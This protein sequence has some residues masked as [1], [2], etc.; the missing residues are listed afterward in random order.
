M[1]QLLLHGCYDS[2]TLHTL[3][4]LGVKRFGFD[5][6]ATS[7]NLVP[8][9]QL[10]TLLSELESAEVVLTFQN[11]KQETVMSFLDLL[12]EYAGNLIVEFRDTQSAAYYY[13]LGHSFYWMFNE[14]ADWQSILRLPSLKGILLPLSMRNRYQHLSEMWKLIEAQGLEV[15]LHCEK[16]ESALELSQFDDTVISLDLNQ[17]VE[18]SYRQVDQSKL[19]E[20]NLWRIL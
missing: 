18:R 16:F 19:K 14:S 8:F 12:K 15:F 2:E 17:E 7:S 5:L 20:L 3:K 4:S 11:D 6:R 10:K 9:A 13:S 1:K